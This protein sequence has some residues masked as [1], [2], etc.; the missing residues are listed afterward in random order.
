MFGL[1]MSFHGFVNLGRRMETITCLVLLV[2]KNVGSPGQ[3][4]LYKRP[5]RPWPAAVKA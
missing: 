4:N 1:K 2:N 3:E 5:Y